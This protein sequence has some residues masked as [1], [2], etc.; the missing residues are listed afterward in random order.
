MDKFTDPGRRDV[1][2]QRKPIDAESQRL[3]EVFPKSL[4]RVD[5]SVAGNGVSPA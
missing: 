4:T 1:E 3:H 2:V 5:Q